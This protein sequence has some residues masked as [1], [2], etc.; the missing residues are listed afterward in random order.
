[1]TKLLFLLF[2]PFLRGLFITIHD[3]GHIATMLNS[4]PEEN[5]KVCGM[6]SMDCE[7]TGSWVENGILNGIACHYLQ[8]C[9]F[10]RKSKEIFPSSESFQASGW[11]SE[12]LPCVHVVKNIFIK[13][14]RTLGNK[15]SVHGNKFVQY[16]IPS[17]EVTCVL[18]NSVAN[19][20]LVRCTKA[21][22]D[23]SVTDLLVW[24]L[25]KSNE[26]C[27]IQNT[28]NSANNVWYP[29]AES[30]ADTPPKKWSC[31]VFFTRA[32]GWASPWHEMKSTL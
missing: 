3:K 25:P 18:K 20:Q 27:G 19:S 22:E 30:I 12:T 2:F 26:S 23:I 10:K 31:E 11:V 21:L 9:L 7:I 15:K 32:R 1:M 28:G 13:G 14:S 4:W 8:N 29:A 5:I 24:L 16:R 6:S 17:K